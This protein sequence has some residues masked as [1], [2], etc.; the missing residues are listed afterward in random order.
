MGYT[1][2]N[3]HKEYWI[4]ITK[5]AE[6]LSTSIMSTAVIVNTLIRR[7]LRG[8][9]THVQKM[10]GVRDDMDK[11]YELAMAYRNLL[12][13]AIGI[14]SEHKPELCASLKERLRELDS[15]NISSDKGN[16]ILKT[17]MDKKEVN[18]GR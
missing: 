11:N 16:G 6:W 9:M 1:A 7:H 5:M 13:D 3:L 15:G 2:L 4:G 8:M 18:H 12:I 14:I 10:E 17:H